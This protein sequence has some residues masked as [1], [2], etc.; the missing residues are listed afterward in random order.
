[1]QESSLSKKDSKNQQEVTKVNSL[2]LNIV[3]KFKSD[4][5]SKEELSLALKTIAIKFTSLHDSYNDYVGPIE[6]ENVLIGNYETAITKALGKLIEY[7]YESNDVFTSIQ[8]VSQIVAQPYDHSRNLWLTADKAISLEERMCLEG[9]ACRHQALLTAQLAFN[10]LRKTL[11]DDK[12]NV[13]I[14]SFKG[15][16]YNGEIQTDGHF[17]VQISRQEDDNEY[18]T[19]FLD[20]TNPHLVTSDEGSVIHGSQEIAE[21]QLTDIYTKKGIKIDEFEVMNIETYEVSYINGNLV[22]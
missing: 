22:H 2:L 18:T 14:V 13:S 9:A 17:F 16:E 7:F 5:L 1:M 10:F 20:I 3:E 4:D 6:I 12:Y 15:H 21:K 19:A 8:K 11:N